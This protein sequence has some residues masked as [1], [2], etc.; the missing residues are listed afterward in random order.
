MIIFF[1]EKSIDGT[2]VI[3]FNFYDYRNSDN[4]IF[5]IENNLKVN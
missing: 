1:E 4:F 3:A 2:S 5:D